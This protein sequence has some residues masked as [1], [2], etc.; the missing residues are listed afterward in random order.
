[1]ILAECVADTLIARMLLMP[2]L[3]LETADIDRSCSIGEVSNRFTKYYANRKAIGIIDKDKNMGK[4][5]KTF[6]VYPSHDLAN[7]T[8]LWNEQTHHLVY[9]KNGLE[10]FINETADQCGMDRSIY[11]AFRTIAQIRTHTKTNQA[12]DDPQLKIFLNAIKTRNPQNFTI[13]VDWVRSIKA[14]N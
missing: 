11:P 5:F 9:F 2:G 14:M 7:M 8:H 12:M 3:N 13:F 6:K 1:M 10:H 4:I